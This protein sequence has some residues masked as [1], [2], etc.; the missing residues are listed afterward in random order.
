MNTDNTRR[1]AIFKAKLTSDGDIVGTGR[2]V[3]AFKV[4][5][6]LVFGWEKGKTI[7]H[8]QWLEP[9]YSHSS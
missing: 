1:K 4:E 6:K 3:G 7:L 5:A 2:T 8:L 9:S